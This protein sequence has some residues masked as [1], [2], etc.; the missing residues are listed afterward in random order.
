MICT[1]NAQNIGFQKKK[2]KKTP[3]FGVF[4]LKKLEK[5]IPDENFWVGFTPDLSKKQISLKIFLR[6]LICILEAL[7]TLYGCAHLGAPYMAF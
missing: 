4:F 1:H 5:K 6:T 3:I 7:K 2:G